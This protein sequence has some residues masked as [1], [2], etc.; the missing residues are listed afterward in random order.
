MIG[1]SFVTV[2][3]VGLGIALTAS[4]ADL[5][6]SKGQTIYRAR[7]LFASLT[8]LARLT[9]LFQQLQVEEIFT[10]FDLCK[11]LGFTTL[12][13]SDGDKFAHQVAIK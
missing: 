7:A 3:L 8:G 1:H 4:A 11:L 5:P 9:P 6:I 12:T 13:I 10:F 2:L